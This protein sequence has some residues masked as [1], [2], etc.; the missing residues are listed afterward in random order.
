MFGRGSARDSWLEFSSWST[1][2]EHR[3]SRRK[4]VFHR[5]HLIVQAREW[6][7]A[8]LMV[9]ASLGLAVIAVLAVLR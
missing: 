1:D 5:H 7:A 6:A 9:V 4:A 3:L 8:A 2:Q